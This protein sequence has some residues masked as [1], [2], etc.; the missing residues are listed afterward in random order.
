[1]GRLS[2][3]IFEWEERDVDLLMSAKRSKLQ[4]AGVPNPTDSAVMKAISQKEMARR[5][6]RGAAETLHLI[7]TLLLSLLGATDTLGV[8]LFRDEIKDI[9]EEQKRHLPCLQDPPGIQL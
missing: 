7:E 6:T 8:P 3:C 9:W 5:R 2:S 1:M 4:S